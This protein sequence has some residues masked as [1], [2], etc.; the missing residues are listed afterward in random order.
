MCPSTLSPSLSRSISLFVYLT[1][2]LT[3]YR[4]SFYQFT[5]CSIAHSVVLCAFIHRSALLSLIE[6]LSLTGYIAFIHHLFL[7]LFLRLSINFNLSLSLSISLYCYLSR[8][9]YHSLPCSL[10]L[11]ISLSLH[12]FILCC[13]IIFRCFYLA[14]CY[15]PFIMIYIFIYV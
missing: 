10:F 9:L 2:S 1:I 7:Y 15:R 14:V 4:Y 12:L 11:S 13:L 8:S 5:S 3:V 6:L